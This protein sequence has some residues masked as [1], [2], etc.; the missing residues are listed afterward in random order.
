MRTTRKTCGQPSSSF[1]VMRRVPELTSH[2]RI[3][4][5]LD[6]LVLPARLLRHFC[7]AVQIPEGLP[8]QLACQRHDLDPRYL[9]AAP[10]SLV[11]KASHCHRI[12]AVGERPCRLVAGGD[13]RVE[14]HDGD[15]GHLSMTLGRHPL[16]GI[17][18]ARVAELLWI[19]ERELDTTRG[20]LAC[21]AFQ[22][23]SA[24]AVDPTPGR[25]RAVAM[26]SSSSSGA[27]RDDKLAPP[28]RSRPASS[29]PE[30][31]QLP[32]MYAERLRIPRYLGRRR[33]RA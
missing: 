13:L 21:V 26:P 25:P 27:L 29:R 24:G 23:R 5:L 32:R 3:G 11:E 17:P 19:E 7:P 9:L 4:V 22:R 28:F 10:N 20:L 1:V 8:V 2:P 6:S 15:A 33:V 14:N 30:L 16:L 18:R 12:L 31:S